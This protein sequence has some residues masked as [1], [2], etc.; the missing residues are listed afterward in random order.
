MTN[1]LYSDTDTLGLD[2]HT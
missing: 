1:E 2:L